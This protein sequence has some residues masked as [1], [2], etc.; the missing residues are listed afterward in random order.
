MFLF[1][2]IKLFYH[3]VTFCLVLLSSNI[4]I[5][6]FLSNCFVYI[7]HVE[8]KLAHIQN[9]IFVLLRNF[10][11]ST[12][13]SKGHKQTIKKNLRNSNF[14]CR[15]ILGETFTGRPLAGGVLEPMC[16]L[17]FISIHCNSYVYCISGV[18]TRGAERACQ[19]S[20]CFY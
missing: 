18:C 11:F 6:S 9:V 15:P 14:Q 5:L 2:Q 1:N 12:K 3:S 20:P 7:Y 4:D 19:R 10:P 16:T 13:R 17:C 8:H